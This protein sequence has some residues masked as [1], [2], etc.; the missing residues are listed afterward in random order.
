MGLSLSPLATAIPLLEV[1]SLFL[2]TNFKDVA[3]AQGSFLLLL[4]SCPGES[5]LVT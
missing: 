3:A 5:S 4:V 2:R 1:N